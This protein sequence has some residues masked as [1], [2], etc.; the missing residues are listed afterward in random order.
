MAAAL[1]LMVAP[2]AAQFSARVLSPSILV[3][4]EIFDCWSVRG[5]DSLYPAV[6]SQRLSSSSGKWWGLGIGIAV[7]AV[8]GVAP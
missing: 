8:G 2:G 7:G 3:R 5:A 6:T 1:V 4:N